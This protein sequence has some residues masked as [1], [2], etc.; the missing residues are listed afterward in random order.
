MRDGG[1]GSIGKVG[2]AI[3]QEDAYVAARLTGLNLIAQTNHGV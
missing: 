1:P 2:G 3:N